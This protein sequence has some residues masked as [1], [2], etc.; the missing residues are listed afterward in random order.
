MMFIACT[1]HSDKNF[2]GISSCDTLSSPMRQALLLLTNENIETQKEKD[3]KPNYQELT[4]VT[5]EMSEQ[6]SQVRIPE[7]SD[8]HVGI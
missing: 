5:R 8:I 6:V 4:N 7:A 2:L 3:F 1:K